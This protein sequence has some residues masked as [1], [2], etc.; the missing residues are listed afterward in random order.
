MLILAMVAAYLLYN[1]QRRLRNMNLTEIN[2]LTK[3]LFRI[4]KGL[5]EKKL[6]DILLK[7]KYADLDI[8]RFEIVAFYRISQN[9]ESL[10]KALKLAH[11]V[12]IDVTSK[13]LLIYSASGGDP[14]DYVKAIIM[15]AESEIDID[16]EFYEMLAL[17]KQSAVEFV[18]IAIKAKP[19]ESKITFFL[20]YELTNAEIRRIVNV[21]L[22]AQKAGV[23]ITGSELLKLDKDSE[24][25]KQKSMYITAKELVEIFRE[26]DIDKY[27]FARIKAHMAELA[28][29]LNTV[30]AIALY[31][32]DVF[33]GLINSLIRAKKNN[34]IIDFEEYVH[35]SMTGVNIIKLI[36]AQVIAKTAEI[37]IELIELINHHQIGGDFYKLVGALAFAKSKNMPIT[38]EEL[39]SK[40]FDG[41]DLLVYVKA[42]F[43]YGE[44]KFEE[45][46][47]VKF[48]EIEAHY[49]NKGR[50]IDVMDNMIKAKGLE[51]KLPFAV[52]TKIDLTDLEN[53]KNNV[54]LSKENDL[55]KKINFTN[56]FRWAFNPDVHEV[57]PEITIV[58]K[59]GIQVMPK[60]TVTLLG[61]LEKYLGGSDKTVIY[62]RLN[63]IMIDE[64]ENY[65]S[66]QDVLL[67]LNKISKSILVKIQKEEDY[68]KDCAYRVMDLNINDID[69]GKDATLELQVEQAHMKAKIHESEAQIRMSE[70][71]AQIRESMAEA[72]KS[73]RLTNFNELHKDE[74][75]KS[76]PQQPN[77]HH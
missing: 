12:N 64:V 14:E 59:Q 13:S 62:S 11:D 6:L 45:N 67:S 75:M 63:E 35:Y 4:N 40:Y 9:I 41:A 54:D 65:I 49:K 51:L 36:D 58:T 77:G 39:L 16:P 50:I 24:E 61:K 52:A 1:P 37:D 8:R 48:A 19:L 33:D 28:L 68:T 3:E 42:L 17:N 74:I 71:E 7:S 38:K 66:H 2:I 21:M 69:I 32:E 23:Y 53:Q 22:K 55:R 44:T 56:A 72:Y 15:A 76:T 27:V 60:V 43:N 26:R 25:F 46:F 10:F 18:S 31:D 34:V 47:G 30:K 29:E 70:A 57:T 20:R 5:E 73:G